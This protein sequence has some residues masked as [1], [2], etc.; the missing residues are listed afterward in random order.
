MRS[1]A[2]RRAVSDP[3][4]L[5]GQGLQRIGQISLPAYSWSSLPSPRASFFP[6]PST[7]A[8][9]GAL[10]AVL[11]G[12]AV[13]DQSGSTQ[14]IPVGLDLAGGS[15]VVSEGLTGGDSVRALRECVAAARARS[16]WAV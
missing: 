10:R 14:N 1:R 12:G 3:R 11:V 13:L 9:W 2:S 7:F 6:A 4:F 15:R 8:Q 16:E 5:G